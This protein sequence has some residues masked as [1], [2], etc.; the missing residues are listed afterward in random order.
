[1]TIRTLLTALSLSLV[2]AVASAG[3]MRDGAVIRNSGSTNT[4]PYEIKFWSDGSAQ[5]LV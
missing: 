4:A 1:M 3:A 2:A 5:L